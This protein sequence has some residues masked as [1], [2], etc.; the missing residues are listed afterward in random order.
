MRQSRNSKHNSRSRSPHSHFS[1]KSANSPPP[2][3]VPISIQQLPLQQIA[4]DAL[5]S[6]NPVQSQNRVK[7]IISSTQ[8]TFEKLKRELNEKNQL[9]EDK[10]REI[11]K[12]KI[13]QEE[14][15]SRNQDLEANV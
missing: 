14:I 9:I 6:H 11:L 15:V 3:T 13:T 7:E 4:T 8:N 5:N 1:N 12:L 10:N 2:D